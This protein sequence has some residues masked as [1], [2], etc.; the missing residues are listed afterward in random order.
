[1]KKMIGTLCAFALCLGCSASYIS[2][3]EPVEAETTQPEN[4]FVE[5]ETNVEESQEEVIEEETVVEETQEVTPQ[6]ET[7]VAEEDIVHFEDEIFENYVK[8]EVDNGD[9]IVTKQEMQNLL[10]INAPNLGIKSVEG[11]QYANIT[12]GSGGIINLEGN[13]I[14]DIT[15]LEKYIRN[16]HIIVNLRNNQ[17]KDF[18]PIYRA[19]LFATALKG[20]PAPDQEWINVLDL[21]DELSFIVEKDDNIFD[22]QSYTIGVSSPYMQG[23]K[24]GLTDDLGLT[25]KTDNEN[26]AYVY[27]NPAWN[28][29]ISSGKQTGTTNIYVTHGTAT[30]TIRVYVGD[31]TATYKDITTT[32][33]TVTVPINSTM[34]LSSFFEPKDALYALHNFEWTSSNENVI[35][36]INTRN[37]GAEDAYK[38]FFDYELLF[39]GTGQATITGTSKTNSNETIS[40]TITLNQKETTGNVTPPTD[41]P[42]DL[43]N[44][45]EDKLNTSDTKKTNETT[46]T[47]TNNPDVPDTGV[48]TNAYL[49]TTLLLV[50]GGYVIIKSTRK[51]NK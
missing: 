51:F 9:G 21:P 11:I 44:D 25:Y 18:S 12:T 34:S 42:K 50:S 27:D 4:T 16:G 19:D 10:N 13:Q 23:E 15:P 40:I 48:E 7:K 22:Y 49:F 14:T 36:V 29:V 43:P 31:G 2:A 17:I 1:M 37:E 5:T 45:T 41:D 6:A 46:K 26:I 24:W 20:N 32:N 38:D 35:K 47:D 8:G 28:V 39:T 30:K 3:Q 33:E